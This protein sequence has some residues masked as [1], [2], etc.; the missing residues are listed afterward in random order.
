MKSLLCSL[1]LTVCAAAVVHADIQAPPVSNQGPTR[2]LSRGFANVAFAITDWQE[3]IAEANDNEGN[4]TSAA[5]GFIRG[6]G[7]FF[8]RTA[9][10]PLRNGH[11]PL[12]A[13]QGQV[14]A[15]FAKRRAVDSQRLFGIPAGTGLGEPL[16]L[17]PLKK[18]RRPKANAKVGNGATTAVLLW[19]SPVP[20]RLRGRLTFSGAD[21]CFLPSAFCIIPFVSTNLPSEA[22]A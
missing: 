8:A 13:G 21:F 7:R 10:R 2:K 14:H 20:V 1:L 16:Q 12:P 17:R 5:F 6:A 4:S 11:V 19:P 9:R 18:V 15:D 3:S 22:A